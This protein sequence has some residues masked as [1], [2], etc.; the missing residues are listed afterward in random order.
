MNENEIYGFFGLLLFAFGVLLYGCGFLSSTIINT[1]CFYLF[2]KY[3]DSE[4]LYGSINEPILVC[5][6]LSTC[7][8]RCTAC[9]SSTAEQNE[10]GRYI[11]LSILTFNISGKNF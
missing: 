8:W 7:K 1:C 9:I 11:Y 3:R 2:S 5:E 4:A 6:S 10:S